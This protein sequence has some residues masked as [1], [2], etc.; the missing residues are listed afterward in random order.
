MNYRHRQESS[1][2]LLIPSE[3]RYESAWFIAVSKKNPIKYSKERVGFHWHHRHRG[4]VSHDLAVTISITPEP[5]AGC[6]QETTG[7]TQPTQGGPCT[8][9]NKIKPLG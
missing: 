5:P 6:T 3:I 9:R 2:C 1:V 4:G 7:C 8:L